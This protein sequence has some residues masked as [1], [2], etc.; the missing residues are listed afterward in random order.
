M[1]L[2]SDQRMVI[3]TLKREGYTN[4]KIIAHFRKNF[5]RNID[6]RT[7]QRTLQRFKNTRNTHD[8]AGRGRKRKCKPVRERA[9]KRAAQG[10]RWL[11]LPAL[12]SMVNNNNS[13]VSVSTVSR[14]LRKFG[15]RRRI[16]AHKPLLT[17][18]QRKKRLQFAKRHAHKELAFWHSKI[19]SD[20]KIFRGGSHRKGAFVTRTKSERN[21]P[22]CVQQS[23]K[24]P[25][26]VHVWGVIGWGGVGALKR[27]RGNLNAAEYRE[28]ILP[29][30]RQVCSLVAPRGVPWTFVQDNA[31]AHRAHS[32][33]SFL[34]DNGVNLL[35][36][37][38]NSPDLNPIENIWAYVQKLMPRRP[39]HNADELWEQVQRAWQSV[40]TRVVRNVID[41]MRRRLDSVARA[42]GNF[43][44]Y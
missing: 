21:K 7:V 24:H 27:V 39:P 37:P 20:E 6:R 15:L 9:I 31:P 10:N 8:R 38:G 13:P 4:E 43:T 32:T 30:I 2:S 18:Q 36:W 33:L 11:S 3:V 40:P 16:A 19:F 26:Q 23:P 29:D 34:Q 1:R 25:L 22:Q 14:T 35:E 12:T 28:Q 5:K 17:V 44:K 42:N 41:S